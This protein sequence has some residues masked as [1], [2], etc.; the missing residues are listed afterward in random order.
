MYVL[1]ELHPGYFRLFSQS[2]KIILI[3]NPVKQHTGEHLES[4]SRGLVGVTF[5]NIREKRKNID[6]WFQVMELPWLNVSLLISR[7][8]VIDHLHSPDPL[9]SQIKCISILS[10]LISRDLSSACEQ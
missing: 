8:M 2:A 10:L 6:R 4:F 3:S 7:D 5:N 9:P 1:I